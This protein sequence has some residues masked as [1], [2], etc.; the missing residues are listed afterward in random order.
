MS[1]TVK[2]RVM[3]RTFAHLKQSLIFQKL[4]KQPAIYKNTEQLKGA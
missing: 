4:L 2:K 1:G 3:V